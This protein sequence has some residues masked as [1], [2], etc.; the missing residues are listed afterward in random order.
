[1]VVTPPL[2]YLIRSCPFIS[3]LLLTNFN[4]PVLYTTNLYSFIEFI[5]LDARL[6]FHTLLDLWLV[7]F[8]AFDNR[9]HLNC[10]LTN[11]FASTR[12]LIIS[13]VSNPIFLSLV[14]LFPS[15]GW[16]ERE[17]WDMFGVFF[18]SNPDLRRILTD[19]G[20]EAFPLRKDFPLTG[21][22]EVRYDDVEKS[23]VNEP[24][25][26]AQSYRTFFFRNLWN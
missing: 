25:E 13:F 6:N 19:Y 11:L 1:M 15:A 10:I 9:F 2:V 21:Y 7:D 8:I 23:V 20:F 12:I 16:L 18:S 5:K 24:F 26:F 14:T 4:F 3:K 22:S 17:V